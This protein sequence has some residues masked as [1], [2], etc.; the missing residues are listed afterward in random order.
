MSTSRIDVL[1]F[2]S[3]TGT[4]LDSTL[5]AANLAMPRIFI[6]IIIIIGSQQRPESWRQLDRS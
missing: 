5:A 2:L 4:V 3:A 6:I 1:F